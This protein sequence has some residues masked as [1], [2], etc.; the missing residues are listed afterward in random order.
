VWLVT[1][2]VSV[3]SIEGFTKRYELHYQ[4]RK[5]DV[6]GVEMLGQYGC[7]NFHAK[8]GGQRAKLTVAIKNK[9]AR[10]RLQGWFHYKVHLIRSLS[11]GRGKGVYTWH[12]WMAELSFIS[13]PPFDC[14]GSDATFVKATH[15]V[16]GL[17]V[18]EEYMA[19]GLFPLLVSFKLC[20]VVNG[21]TPVSKLSGAMMDF[22]VAR[23]SGETND[24]FWVRVELATMNVVR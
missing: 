22:L 7:I 17:D 8:H 20:E 12:S 9:W 14:P 1:S 4:S 21:E 23:L 18:V 16:G 13:D 24:C 6:D 15:T 5:V 19:C 3:L 2:F 10:T 11:P